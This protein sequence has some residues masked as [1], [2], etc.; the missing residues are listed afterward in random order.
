MSNYIGFQDKNGKRHAERLGTNGSAAALVDQFL[1]GY[2]TGGFP[3]S[4]RARAAVR[5]MRGFAKANPGYKGPGRF[6]TFEQVKDAI[7]LGGDGCYWAE[8]DRRRVGMGWFSSPPA[9]PIYRGVLIPILLTSINDG[10]ASIALPE[11][12]LVAHA[13]R[14]VLPRLSASPAIRRLTAMT[15]MAEMALKAGSTLDLG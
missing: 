11:L 8:V 2:A 14:A 6:T 5:L 4:A 15:E 10:A 12:K 9:Y 13:W 1:V 3:Q 7:A